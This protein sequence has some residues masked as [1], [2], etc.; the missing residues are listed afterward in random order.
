MHL[1]S[2]S[3]SIYVAGHRG[4][5]GSAVVDRLHTEGF[6]R[7]VTRTRQ[8]LDLRDQAATEAFFRDE[9]PDFVVLAAAR[10]GGILANDRYGGDF[11]YDNLAIQT[12][13]IRAAQRNGVRRLIFPGSTCAYPKHADQPLKE[14]YLLTGP[15][16]P[17]NRPY[18]VAKIAGI[19]M[20]RAFADQYGS[21]FWSLMPSNLY[22]PGDN[23]DL[24]DSHVVPALIRK[25][26]E[27]AGRDD[28]TVTVWGSG[29]PRREFLYRDDLADAIVHV[30]RTP[31]SSLEEVAPD[32][33]LNVGTGREYTIADLARTI[34]DLVDGDPSIEWDRSRPDGTP[35]KLVDPG[36]MRRI[37]WE[38]STS[39]EEGLS[40]TITWY[41]QKAEKVH[42]PG[43][44]A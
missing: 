27:A 22:G 7:I 31:A 21:D 1:K 17:T 33:L 24:E 10:V 15:L 37:G 9:E 35:R 16:E 44:T 23:F 32:R 36:R 5:V 14:E 26:V 34:R 43:E 19:E 3:D 39:L 12:N 18:A 20:C 28:E 42:A 8:E 40:R 25:F 11:I 6:D 41:R 2:R 38:A 4:M 30:L 13:V 29:T